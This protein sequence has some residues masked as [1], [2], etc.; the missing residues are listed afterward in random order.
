[1]KHYRVPTQAFE[2]V[3]NA[4]Q[5]VNDTKG[6]EGVHTLCIAVEMMKESSSIPAVH[7]WERIEVH[8]P[9][10][11]GKNFAI[12]RL[13]VPEGWIYCIDDRL[14]LIRDDTQLDDAMGQFKAMF[15]VLGIPMPGGEVVHLHEVPD[16]EEPA[17]NGQ[18]DPPEPA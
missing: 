16:G 6:K 17:D 4:A 5:V 12:H 2:N 13:T 8:G 18:P 15:N 7:T 1:M 10:P 14:V 9:L 11:Q 3:I